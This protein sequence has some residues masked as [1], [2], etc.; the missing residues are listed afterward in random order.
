V[1][2][3]WF[4]QSAFLL[5][6]SQQRVLIDPFGDLSTMGRRWEYPPVAD[7]ACDLRVITHEHRDHNHTEAATGDPFVVRSQAGT[8]DTPVGEV[9]S[10]A[11]EHDTEAG[12]RRGA[13]TLVRFELDGL[14]VAHLGDLGQSALRAEQLAALGPIEVLFVPCGGMATIDAAG[15]AA[16]VR[17]LSPR[18]AVPMH[19]RTPAID[20]L[21]PADAFLA[22]FTDVD[23]WDGPEGDIGAAPHGAIVPS[24]PS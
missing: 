13:N 20:F 5:E 12:I 8:F 1:R 9:V 10:V 11:S 3:R 15:A 7:V 18:W 24:P 6:G 16:A 14:R 22:T 2:L 17:A 4:G 21:E 19:Y 23:R